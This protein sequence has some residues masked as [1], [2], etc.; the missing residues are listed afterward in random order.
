[1]LR[2]T[3]SIA[4][5]FQAEP[6]AAGRLLLEN[7]CP[8]VAGDGAEKHE[9]QPALTAWHRDDA[10]QCPTLSEL[11]PP[12]PGRHGWP[13]TEE[14]PRAPDATIDDSSWPLISIVTPSFNQGHFIEET[15]RSILLQGYPDLEYIIIDGGSTDNTL[16]IIDKYQPW[17]SYVVSE[18]DNGQNDAIKKG[19][20][21]STGKILAWLNSD[22]V[23]EP[24]SLIRVAAAWRANPNAGLWHGL[25]HEFDE[26]GVK[27]TAGGPY[28]VK[29]AISVSY[30]E[31][32]RVAQPAAFI[33]RAAIDVGMPDVRLK[34]SMD[35]DL[36]QR[37]AAVYD[38][39]FIPEVL[40]RFRLHWGQLSQVRAR[41]PQFLIE[42]ER[43][44]A[45]E[46]LF[47]IRNLPPSV[48][49]LRRKALARTHLRLA[50]EL[51]FAGAVSEAFKH[52]RLSFASEATALNDIECLRSLALTIFGPKLSARISSLKRRCF[53]NP[54]KAVS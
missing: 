45:L 12:P 16:G 44:M 28:D 43:L 27:R 23:Y 48:M 8:P 32:G 30:D 51:R 33:S 9:L 40:A 24:N 15:I 36:F 52:L 4:R 39:V 34:Q 25:C 11:P 46:N 2:P 1:M 42:R 7:S 21:R 26:G 6:A 37:V 53:K 35:K 29:T 50:Q 41:D 54:L 5:W 19:W 10:M 13:W 3:Q 22:D 47:A 49:C 38:A 31:G 14:T 20:K 17:L 18:P